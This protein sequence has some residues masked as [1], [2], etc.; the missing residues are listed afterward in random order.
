MF[1]RSTSASSLV[2]GLLL[3]GAARLHAEQPEPDPCASTVTRGELRLCWAREVDRADT[4]MRQ[5]LEAVLAGFPRARLGDLKKAQKA[6]YDFRNAQLRALYGG[7]Q[8]D[9][10]LFTCSLIARVQLTRA[11]TAAL[12]RMLQEAA[13]AQVCP[14]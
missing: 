1:R 14:L 3:I 7:R 12:K 13:D 5:A 6:W 2:L 4:E 9:L 8:H 11:R 10:E